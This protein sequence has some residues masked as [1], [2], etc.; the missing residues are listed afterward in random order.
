MPKFSADL[1]TCKCAYFVPHIMRMEHHVNMCTFH[2]LHSHYES[3]HSAM[4]VFYNVWSSTNMDENGRQLFSN[5]LF[6]SSEKVKVM[7]MKCVSTNYLVHIKSYLE[8]EIAWY[9]V[10]FI[11]KSK[12]TIWVSPIFTQYKACIFQN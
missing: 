9:E 11:G 8:D 3:G 6:I 2:S 12:V 5:K 4:G 10:V 1:Y 7:F